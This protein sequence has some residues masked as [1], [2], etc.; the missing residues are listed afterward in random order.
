MKWRRLWCEMIPFKRSSLVFMSCLYFCCLDSCTLWQS[1]VN[2]PSARSAWFFIHRAPWW[3]LNK[4]RQKIWCHESNN[5]IE[6]WIAEWNWT[7]IKTF[8]ALLILLTIALKT[9][10]QFWSPGSPGCS[11]KNLRRNFLPILR[12]LHC[13]NFWEKKRDPCKTWALPNHVQSALKEDSDQD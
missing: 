12:N 13:F 11:D 6:L 1:V 7:W 3:L 9:D 5:Q 2:D 8:W 10:K 4:G